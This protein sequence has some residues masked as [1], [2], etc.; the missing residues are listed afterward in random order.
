MIPGIINKL[1]NDLASSD[2]AVATSGGADSMALCHLCREA[3]LNFTVIIVDHKYRKNSYQEATNA[4]NELSK[5][6]TL[7]VVILENKEEI[8]LSNVEKTLRDIRYNLII[9]YCKTHEIDTV[10]TAHHMDDNVETFLMRLERG[11]SI[12]GLSGIKEEN[13]IDGIRFYR[14]LLHMQKDGLIGYLK[15]NHMKYFHDESNDDTR[16]TRNSIRKALSDISDYTV[17]KKRISGI[18]SSFARTNDFIQSE[19]IKAEK[20]VFLDKYTID[21]KQFLSLHEELGLRILKRKFLEFYRDKNKFRFD[22]IKRVYQF[23][24]KE[25]GKTELAGVDIEVSDTKIIFKKS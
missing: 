10:L 18:I 15:Q 12:E 11:S 22:K 2:F 25:T 1:K 5:Y 14:P 13:Y 17:L 21:K 7:N 24:Q 3:G 8:P 19:L 20:K 6:G 4:K 9:D 23:I 16:F